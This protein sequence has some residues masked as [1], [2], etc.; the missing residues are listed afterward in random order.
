MPEHHQQRNPWGA[1]LPNTAQIGERRATGARARVFHL[2]QRSAREGYRWPIGQHLGPPGAVPIWV[3]REPWA[4]GSSGA[5]RMRDLRRDFGCEIES[6]RFDP[7]DGSSSTFVY[8]LVS[9]PR[10]RDLRDLEVY[11]GTAVSGGAIH[12]LMGDDRLAPCRGESR[13]EYVARL[14][15]MPTRQLLY[16]DRP[17]CL[18]AGPGWELL[19]GW[20]P[21][22]AAAGVLEQRGA[23]ILRPEEHAA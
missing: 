18:V 1:P 9:T 23:R 17:L 22:N 8:T 7:G 6:F 11:A 4:G 16:R 14:Q 19:L 21:V 3:L 10:A 2:L 20:D 13:A 5:R 15:A 12:D